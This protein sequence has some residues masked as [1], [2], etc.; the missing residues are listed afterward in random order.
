MLKGGD[1]NDSLSGGDGNDGLWGNAGND[2][3]KGGAGHDE[4]DGE[5][6]N[7]LILGGA[8]NDKIFAGKD[9]DIIGGNEGG[10][11]LFGGDGNDTAVGG[12]GNDTINGGTGDDVI[13]GDNYVAKV[14]LIG[15]DLVNNGSFENNRVHPGRRGVFHSLPGW[16]TTFGPGIEV[17]EQAHKFG[18][19]ADGHAWVEL[20]SY[21][22]SGMAQQIDTHAGVTYQLSVDYT[23]RQY[24]SP[25]KVEVWWDGEKVTTLSGRGG[26]SNNWNTYTFEVEGSD[27]DFTKLEF[28]AAGHSNGV[29]GFI[30]NVQ[31]FRVANDPL[32]HI[33]DPAQVVGDDKLF[34]E[35]GNDTLFGGAG[36]DTLVGGAGNDVLH[37]TDSVTAGANQEDRINGGAGYDTFVLA[38]ANGG[39]YNTQGWHDCV[40]IHDFTAHEDTIQL[41]EDAH[42][43]L[44]SW[45]G[46]SYL[47]EY[48]EHS[49]D[50]VAVLEN[51]KL[52]NHDLNNTEL[53]EYV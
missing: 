26:H 9:N 5:D 43:W 48:T 37:G 39:F 31:V 29:G 41:S 7:D 34:G 40:V 28:R 49:W 47:Y 3:L 33:F 19:A 24:V 36:S 52:Y 2:T 13:Y 35:D 23:P 27:A 32:A 21:G 38:D 15:H 22:N 8:G 30:D 10:D 6:G 53:F 51:T 20:D 4:L 11:R 1:G 17:K 14:D 45:E 42:Y 12:A 25:S 18:A 44:G 16:H 46:D 50:G